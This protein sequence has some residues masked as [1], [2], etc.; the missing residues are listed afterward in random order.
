M[1]NNLDSS[2]NL[3][4][5]EIKH[6][7]EIIDNLKLQILEGIKVRSRVQEASLGEIPSS[8]LLGKLKTNNN[9]KVNEKNNSRGLYR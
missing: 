4:Y 2:E 6:L 9:K 8:Y 3:D 7:K 5:Q 1:Y